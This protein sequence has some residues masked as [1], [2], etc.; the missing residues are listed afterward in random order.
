MNP[1][2]LENCLETVQIFSLQ[3]TA[4]DEDL[5]EEEIERL[6][7]VEKLKSFNTIRR[8]FHFH[9]NVTDGYSDTHKSK[10]KNF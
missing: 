10:G 1:S 9:E 4:G 6:W 2:F 7:K 5:N 8:R 3:C